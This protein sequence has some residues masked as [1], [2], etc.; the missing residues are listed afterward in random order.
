MSTPRLHPGG[1]TL[2]TLSHILQTHNLAGTT[3]R[4]NRCTAI[5]ECANWVPMHGKSSGKVPVFVGL[6]E[7]EHHVAEFMHAVRVRAVV[8]VARVEHVGHPCAWN[9]TQQLG[10]RV[11]EKLGV[12][13]C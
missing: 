10:P 9:S 7:I 6:G 13:Q 12:F 1:T 3:H 8:V 5:Q 2:T 11:E 4:S